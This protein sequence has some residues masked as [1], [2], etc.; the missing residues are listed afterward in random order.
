MITQDTESEGISMNGIRSMYHKRLRLLGL[1]TIALALSVF[2][3]WG[4]GGT[5]A[6]GALP[7]SG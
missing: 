2:G 1:G 6:N 5:V 4:G 7:N 3:S